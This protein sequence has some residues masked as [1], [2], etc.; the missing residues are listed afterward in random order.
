MT[1]T[2]S[3]EKATAEQLGR[4]LDAHMTTLG[5]GAETMGEYG[6]TS[7]YN[8]PTPLPDRYR[9][10][11][12]FAAE[13]ENEGYYVHVGCIDRST[14]IDLCFA[15]T[16]DEDHAYQLAREAQRFLNVARWNG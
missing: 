5:I 1:V 15:K 10:L 16:F 13:G 9:W 8:E 7:T 6:F 12:A 14:Y 3:L 2:Y 11:I 4:A